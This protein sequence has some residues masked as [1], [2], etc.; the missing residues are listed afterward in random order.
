MLGKTVCPVL[1]SHFVQVLTCVRTERS[2]VASKDV[3]LRLMEGSKKEQQQ[4]CCYSTVCCYVFISKAFDLIPRDILLAKLE[5]Y[6]VSLPCVKLLKSYLQH[7]RQRVL[8]FSS[9]KC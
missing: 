8:S 1:R 4:V 9:K 6:G 2:T 7:R 5:A 3:L